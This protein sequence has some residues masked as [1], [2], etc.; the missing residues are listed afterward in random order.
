LIPGT[1]PG[2]RLIR[3]LIEE[4]LMPFLGIVRRTPAVIVLAVLAVALSP[5][6]SPAGIVNVDVFN[7]DFGTFNPATG[8]GVHNDPTIHVGDTIHWVFQQGSHDTTS[9]VGQTESWA[10]PSPMAVGST[11]DHT[12]TNVGNFTYICTIHGIDNGNGTAIGMQGIIHV[13]AVP[14]PSIILGISAIGMAIG[15]CCAR[16][17]RRSA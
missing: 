6:L 4:H 17:W 7:L 12:F 13:T 3:H 2:E 5:G 10:S 8:T 16:R 11:F 14:E 9:L 1:A 15:G